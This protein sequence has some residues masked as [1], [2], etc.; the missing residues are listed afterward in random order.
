[1]WASYRRY[2]AAD[3]TFS[4]S[5]HNASTFF[6]LNRWFS[7]IWRES[8][9]TFLKYF[10]L[11]L[12]SFILITLL[13]KFILN[14]EFIHWCEWCSMYYENIWTKSLVIYYLGLRK[15]I[16]K[17]IHFVETKQKFPNQHLWHKKEKSRGLFGLCFSRV[18]K[19]FMDWHSK[20]FSIAC[21]SKRFLQNNF[22]MRCFSLIAWTHSS[23]WDDI[24]YRQK[25][26]LALHKRFASQKF[27]LHFYQYSMAIARSF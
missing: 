26:L 22:L 11:V 6:V 19:V 10:R 7:L 24:L 14:C 23:I 8:T 15:I 17:N 13:L 1:M 9:P 5:I 16:N 27:W 18:N 2:A 25:G 3:T 20:W 21:W 4:K 12:N